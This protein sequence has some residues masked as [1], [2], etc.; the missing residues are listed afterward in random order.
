MTFNFRT[1]CVVFFTLFV[2]LLASCAESE[3]ITD[4]E[5]TTES[6]EKETNAPSKTTS[7]TSEASTDNEVGKIYSPGE[8]PLPPMTDEEQA[9]ADSGGATK[10]EATP[11]SQTKSL[12]TTTTTQQQQSPTQPSQSSGD[13]N[14]Y[15]HE[16]YLATSDNLESWDLS[17]EAIAEHASMPD[18]LQ[19]Q[20]DIG[21]FEAGTLLLT[22]VDASDMAT[23][24]GT[25]NI[26]LQYSTD[27]GNTWSER[28]IITIEGTEDEIPVDPSLVQLDDGTLLLYYFDFSEGMS[29]S[30]SDSF[31]MYVASSSDGKTFTQEQAAFTYNEYMTDPEVVYFDSTWYMYFVTPGS[32]DIA[33]ASSDDGLTFDYLRDTG[34]HGVPGTLVVDTELQLYGCAVGTASGITRST[35]SDGLSF[36]DAEVILTGPGQ[37]APDLVGLDDGTYF[38]AVNVQKI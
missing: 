25:E 30:T 11:T 14:I 15:Y 16:I 32:G 23:S 7:E 2:L 13:Q 4:S 24:S 5:D 6:V 8:Q 33:V 17:D 37:C 19:L 22:F 34:I 31:S 29:F 35:S 1:A 21:D 36:S 20:Q 28:I 18:I 26:G 27:H 12:V 10:T 9:A 3:K 38:M